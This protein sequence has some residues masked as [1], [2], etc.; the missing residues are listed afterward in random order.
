MNL[1]L[2]VAVPSG[3]CGGFWG[4]GFWDDGSVAGVEGLC[5]HE[6]S[7]SALT[8]FR[9]AQDS[10]R[11]HLMCSCDRFFVLGLSSATPNPHHTRP[12]SSC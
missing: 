3:F 2:K 6:A 12:D 10:C 4:L 8:L 9:I 7:W 1:Q 11:G 5:I